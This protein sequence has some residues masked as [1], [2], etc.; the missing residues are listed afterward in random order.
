[1]GLLHWMIAA[2]SAAPIV[3]AFSPQGAI[4]WLPSPTTQRTARLSAHRNT[5]RTDVRN[6]LTQRAFQSFIDVLH[7]CRDNAT[8]KWL[9]QTYGFQNLERYRGTAGID[10]ER[11]SSWDAIFIDMLDRPADVIVISAKRRGRGHGGWSKDNPFLEEVCLFVFYCI[12][13]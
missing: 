3:V 7:N 9:E 1:M 13:V 11:F 12:H 6:L 2:V 5:A 4:C 8:V 10:L